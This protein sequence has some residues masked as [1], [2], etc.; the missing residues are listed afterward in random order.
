MPSYSSSP[1]SNLIKAMRLLWGGHKLRWGKTECILNLRC[2]ILCNP[3]TSETKKQVG[4]QQ[5]S[6]I[7]GRNVWGWDVDENGLELCRM[8]W[9]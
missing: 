8:L 7:L 4:G 3:F 9:V 1:F 6:W 2:K 5:L